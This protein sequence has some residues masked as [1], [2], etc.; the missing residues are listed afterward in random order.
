MEQNENQP[1]FVKKP[2]ETPM[3]D[4]QLREQLTRQPEP[5]G[6]SSGFKAFYRANKFYFW[7]IIIGVAIIGVLAYFAFRKPPVVAP[8]E[9]NVNINVSVPETVPSGAE[10]VYKITVQNNDSQ[11]LVKLEL[12]LAYDDGMIYQSSQPKTENLS[13]TL[14]GIPDLLPGQNAAVFLKA[15]VSGSVNDQKTLNLKL[16]YSY[17][18]FNSEFVKSASSVV[19]LV[20]SDVVLELGGPTQANNAEPVV[21]TVKYQNNSSSEIKNARIKMTYPA[22]FNFAAATPLASLGNDTWNLGT[23]AQNGSGQIQIQGS[24]DAAVSAGESK[25]V[26]AEFLS[27]GSDGQF[28]SQN[29]SEFITAIS[30]L[31]LL[32][33]QTLDNNTSGVVDPGDNL[34]IR[35]RYQNNARTA[36]TG[37][38]IQVDLDSRAVDLTSL[39]A[40]GAQINNSTIVWNAASVSQLE[41]LRPNDSGQL[42][43]SFKLNN[44][45]TKDSSKNLTLISSLKIKSNEY[46]S[47]FPGNTLNL[48]IS[49]PAAIAET[50]SF[51][52]GSLPPQVGKATVYKIRLA[53]TNSSNDFTNGVLTAFLPAGATSGSFTSSESN[54]VQYDSALNKL[55][56]TFGQLPANTGRF[57]QP[58]ILEFQIR[59]SPSASQ[60]HQS[61]ILVKDINFT[62]KDA[63][64]GQDVSVLG[65][66]ITT[67]NLAGQNGYNGS[68]VP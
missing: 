56:W 39:R 42:S 37:V 67:A 34:T 49:S 28:Y 26:K 59:L 3:I 55:I 25:T 54:N 43:F 61:P 14:F 23:L 12:E 16:H 17:S 11:K 36:A 18:N 47:Y 64:T 24:F 13:G 50:L 15:K 44:P 46:Q 63:F 33:S 52:S 48:K 31:P 58:K 66:N 30:S 60:V 41:N 21:Y 57:S 10:A 53:L 38:N 68:V 19:R 27:L 2:V 5:D 9:A 40:E 45:A 4:S 7:A 22:G 1:D 20:A 62:A 51:I 6:G 32:I 35:L 29:T 8:K 65:D